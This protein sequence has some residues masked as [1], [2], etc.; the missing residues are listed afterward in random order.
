MPGPPR[1]GTSPEMQRLA[2]YEFLIQTRLIAIVRVKTEAD[3]PT[4]AAAIRRGGIEA[5][6]FT[7]N[8]PDALGAIRAC[9]QSM[10]GNTLIGAGT[11]LTPA[12]AID[13]AQAGARFLVSPVVDPD[14]I[15]AAHAAGCAAV[16]GAYTPTEMAQA[17]GFGADLIKL[18]PA[19]GLGAAYVRDVLAPL[20][21][22]KLVPTG[23]VSAENAGA[24]LDAGA[25]ALAVGTSVTRPEWVAAKDYDA[26]EQAARALRDAVA[27]WQKG[28]P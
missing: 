13:A 4:I 2:A 11:V 16:P 23:G 8:S 6:E 22:I 25:A 14:V 9:A 3:L 24:Y 5:I 1:A 20:Q 21:H 19:S 26:M 28:R 7:M 10:D 15:E 27:A 12:Q 18:F 17:D